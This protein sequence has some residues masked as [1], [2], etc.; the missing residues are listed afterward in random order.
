MI[1]RSEFDDVIVTVAHPWG[2]ID[3]TLTEWASRGPGAR[4][5]VTIVRARRRSTGRPVS[6]EEIPLEYHN[7]RH[8]RTLQREG[9]LPT[10]WGPPPDDVQQAPLSALPPEI[11]DRIRRDRGE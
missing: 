1:D 9:R 5:L 11:R 4:P 10:P 2:D 8:S 3:A 6:L 7:T